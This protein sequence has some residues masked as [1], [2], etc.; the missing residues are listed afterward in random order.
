MNIGLERHP[1]SHSPIKH[2]LLKPLHPA[3]HPSLKTL[4]VNKLF[5]SLLHHNYVALKNALN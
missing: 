1:L 3:F 2:S 4:S 5:I